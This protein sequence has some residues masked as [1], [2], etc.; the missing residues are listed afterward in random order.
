MW[1]DSNDYHHL[2]P[3][4]PNER[5]KLKDIAKKKIVT[6]HTIETRVFEFSIN[7]GKILPKYPKYWDVNKDGLAEVFLR[8]EL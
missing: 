2:N 7:N 3:K 1:K 8:F 6:L 5:T 4:I